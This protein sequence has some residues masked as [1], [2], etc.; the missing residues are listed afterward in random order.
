MIPK[1]C[2]E[3]SWFTYIG[4]EPNQELFPGNPLISAWLRTLQFRIATENDV[5][6]AASIA[7]AWEHEIKSISEPGF[8]LLLKLMFL[9]ETTLQFQVPF[10][11]KKIISHMIELTLLMEAPH[12]QS[13]KALHQ[14]QIQSILNARFL[15]FKPMHFSIARCSDTNQLNQLVSAIEEQPIKIQKQLLSQLN[16]DDGYVSQLLIS[17]LFRRSNTESAEWSEFMKVCKRV[18]NQSF[19][20]Q[21]YSLMAS[22]FR[23]IATVQEEFLN[24][25]KAA[26][27][28]LDEYHE[29]VHQ[30]H[31]IIEDYQATIFFRQKKY[32]DALSIWQAILPKW[33]E[34]LN[35]ARVF[36]YRYAEISAAQLK[37]WGEA[38]EMALK[39]E[40]LAKQGEHVGFSIMS[41]GF[42]ADRAF[43]L[44]KSG[45]KADAIKVFA[46]VID[47]FPK[48]PDPQQ[49]LHS[50]TIQ[51]RVGHAITYLKQS[52]T[53]FIELAEPEVGCFSNLEVDEKIKDYPL[54]PSVFLWLQLAEIEFNTK[55]GEKCFNRLEKE[56]S[57]YSFPLLHFQLELLRLNRCLRNL[58]LGNLVSMFKKFIIGYTAG[59]EHNKAGKKAYDIGNLIPKNFAPNVLSQNVDILINLFYSALVKLAIHEK[60]SR[61]PIKQWKADTQRLGFSNEII[62]NWFSF[63][64]QSLQKP[65]RE[66]IHVLI[67]AMKDEQTESNIKLLCCLLVSLQE[68]VKPEDCFF[69]NVRIIEHPNPLWGREIE[70]EIELI[71]SR[72]WKKIAAEQR[73]AILS[74]NINTPAILNACDDSSHG[75]KKAARILLAAKDAVRILVHE[76]IL[77]QLRKLAQ[78]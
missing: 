19:H 46:K 5:E 54:G 15:V 49:D 38:A 30:E 39:G 50:Y 53:D 48:L 61:A 37:D 11:Q 34:G 18:A 4:L 68:E 51:K 69:A 12:K 64:E 28:T 22:A 70:N 43:I 7:D 55:S 56:S 75:F 10:S 57:K 21:L 63:F 45:K 73:F 60:F 35:S 29:K 27:S 13:S 17:I 25:T 47:V 36:S 41:L 77:Q 66:W 62:E 6:I 58:E 9:L 31:P 71:I 65:T 74:P 59:S 26:L 2:H 33:R 1:I 3:L 23:A 32:N 24:N 14:N 72:S 67:S 42:R 44:W 78:S 40:E 20:L 16:T 52:T 8:K 76:Q